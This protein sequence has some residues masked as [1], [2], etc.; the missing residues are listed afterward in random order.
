MKRSHDMFSDS[1]KAGFNNSGNR[2]KSIRRKER[3]HTLKYR[4]SAKE[5]ETNKTFLN[6]LSNYQI[7]G[8]QVSMQSK[9]SNSF[10]HPW[11]TT[12]KILNTNTSFTD[13]TK[14][15]IRFMLTP[16]GYHWFSLLLSL[17]AIRTI[18]KHNLRRLL[19]LGQKLI[20]HAMRLWL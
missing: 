20:R 11:P 19:L 17:R 1:K 6:Y 4:L 18:S 9:V 15:Y 5:R 12:C 8:C 2:T 7:S 14:N 13:K 10:Q 3:R 16:T